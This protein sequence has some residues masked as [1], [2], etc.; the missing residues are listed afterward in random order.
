[1]RNKIEL[2]HDSQLNSYITK[3]TVDRELEVKPQPYDLFHSIGIT[4]WWVLKED[5]A[6]AAVTPVKKSRKYKT[7]VGEDCFP[8]IDQAFIYLNDDMGVAHKDRYPIDESFW[9][10]LK[11]INDFLYELDTNNGVTML[12]AYFFDNVGVRAQ[13]SKDQRSTLT[14]QLLDWY[15]GWRQGERD[16]G[17]C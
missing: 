16:E 17:N 2:F 9:P 1:M 12:T 14:S 13:F 7:Y 6:K 10:H 3:Y 8:D 4:E 11:D 5:V 15:C